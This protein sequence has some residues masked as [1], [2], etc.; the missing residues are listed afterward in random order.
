MSLGTL[1]YGGYALARPGH[2][3]AFLTDDA[4]R[5]PD[6]DLLARMYGVRD[7]TIGALGLLGRSDDTVTAALLARIAFD[8]GDGMLLARE[9]EDDATRTKVLGLTFG[10]AALNAAA[11]VTDR[12][13][14]RRPLSNRPGRPRS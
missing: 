13:R 6:Y 1:V 7:T 8:V 5:R 9:A 14:R 11:L 4:G 10:W 2:L 3:G 12:R